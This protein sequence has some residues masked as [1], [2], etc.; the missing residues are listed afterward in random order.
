MIRHFFSV[1]LAASLWFYL[2]L[3][4]QENQG[5]EVV[6]TVHS[7][8]WEEGSAP[9]GNW[10][11]DDGFWLDEIPWAVFETPWPGDWES[12][13]SLTESA[14]W[15]EIPEASLTSRQQ[16][17]L[18][19]DLPAGEW[20][21]SVIAGAAQWKGPLLRWNST[22]EVFERLMEVSCAFGRGWASATDVFSNRTREWPAEHPLSESTSVRLSISKSG[23]YRIDRAWM[24]DA[25]FDPDT[26]DPRKVQ[27]FGNG[28]ALLP[29]DN[30]EDRPLGL[31]TVAVDFSGSEDGSWDEGDALVFWGE[32][33]DWI[34]WNSSGSKWEHLRHP[35]EDKAWYFLAIDQELDEGRISPATAISGT[36]DTVYT[37][38]QNVQFHEQELES[39]N[40]SGRE[41]FG[42]SFGS[43]NQ[44]TFTFATPYPTGEPAK[45]SGRFAAQSMGVQSSFSVTSGDIAF[46]AT[47][48]YTSSTST[49]N[50]A[51]LATASAEGAAA[52]QTGLE[53]DD[54]LVSVQ[55]S[56]TKGVSTAMGWLDY[57]LVEQPCH[58][59][60]DGA[61][62]VFAF[63][64]SMG[65][66]AESQLLSEVDGVRVWDIT[67]GPQPREVTLEPMDGG[68]KWMLTSDT[69]RAYVAF[70]SNSLL[71]PN[72]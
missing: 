30:S 47:P 14:S 45:V 62:L 35:Y 57:L 8:Q 59:K 52:S 42:E 71:K 13:Q 51:N 58:L 11:I 50:V 18:K 27:L 33:P 21:T 34:G 31:R 32:G 43:I 25:G 17:L 1:V 64:A 3:H 67:D 49:S 15:V 20:S 44:R 53:A 46:D 22:K 10:G 26:I 23:L 40:R 61:P 36:P 72:F 41:W 56:F 68:V 70:A 19:A 63:P 65:E 66:L 4:A 69:T 54:A 38:Y 24:I 48:S 7:V 5:V 37:R 60:F 39:P 28:G 29:M 16:Q 9:V 6:E 55:V 12:G 2:P